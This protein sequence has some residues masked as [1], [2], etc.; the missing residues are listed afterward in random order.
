LGVNIWAAPLT[1]F[2][3]LIDVAVGGGHGVI[4]IA[5]VNG[6]PFVLNAKKFTA[7]YNCGTG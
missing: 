2:K 4:V 7:E 3:P 1:K 5:F 6:N